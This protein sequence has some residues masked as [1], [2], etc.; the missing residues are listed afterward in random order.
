MMNGR[1][2]GKT[3]KTSPVGQRCVLKVRACA[4]LD[5]ASMIITMLI[6]MKT[7]DVDKRDLIYNS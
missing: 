1:V 6:M 3:G 5:R 7:M 4:R 2:E